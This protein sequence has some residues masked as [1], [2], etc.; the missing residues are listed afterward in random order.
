MWWDQLG[1]WPSWVAVTI[2]MVVAFGGLAL[3]LAVALVQEFH[4]RLRWADPR[5]WLHTR[6]SHGDTDSQ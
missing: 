2:V 3:L 6:S 1:S 5:R 4:P